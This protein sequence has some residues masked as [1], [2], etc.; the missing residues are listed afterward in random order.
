MA[1]QSKA[2]PADTGTE[3][4]GGATDQGDVEEYTNAEEQGGAEKGIIKQLR[5][6]KAMLRDGMSKEEEDAPRTT[7]GEGSKRGGGS[8]KKG[9]ETR[10]GVDLRHLLRKAPRNGMLSGGQHGKTRGRELE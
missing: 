6:K 2:M 4:Q 10:G 9:R 7:R 1:L 3:I 8:K 5:T